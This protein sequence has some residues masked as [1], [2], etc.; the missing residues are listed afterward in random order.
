MATNDEKRAGISISPSI[1]NAC[2]RQVVLKGYEQYHEAPSDYYARWSGDG[3]HAM[4][5]RHGPYEGIIQEKRI[6]KMFFDPETGNNAFISGQMD[7]WDYEH[8]HLADWKK[9]NKAPTTPYDDHERQVNI[10][11]W[12]LDGGVW[13]DGTVSEYGPET[14]EIIY[15]EPKRCRIVPVMLWSHEAVE[16]MIAS[17]LIPFVEHLRTKEL[18]VGLDKDGPDY[19]KAQYCPFRGTGKCCAD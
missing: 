11:A 8:R 2:P 16:R 7:W 17:R 4:I 5:E 15:L 9:T 14:A 1:L 18:P 19:W 13:E 10:Y 3:V 12:L 6:K